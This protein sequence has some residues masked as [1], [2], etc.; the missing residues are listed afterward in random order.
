METIESFNYQMK[1]PYSNYDFL[2]QEPED[3]KQEEE[4]PECGK[5]ID[6]CHCYSPCCGA[7]II[8]H[9]ICSECGEH[10]I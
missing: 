9:D 3:V 5:S 6:E 2:N 7:S 4:C 8:C 1:D 10:C